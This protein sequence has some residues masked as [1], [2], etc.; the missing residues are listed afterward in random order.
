M[1]KKSKYLKR[2]AE[3][4]KRLHEDKTMVGCCRGGIHHRKDGSLPKRMDCHC[5]RKGTESDTKGGKG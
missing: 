5:Y 4:V 2:K 3:K 1:S